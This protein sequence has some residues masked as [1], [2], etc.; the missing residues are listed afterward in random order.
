MWK[1]VGTSLSFSDMSLV[2]TQ[3]SQLPVSIAT[4]D[5]FSSS[6]PQEQAYRETYGEGFPSDIEGSGVRDVVDIPVAHGVS[7]LTAYG[8][9][10][11]KGIIGAKEQGECYC[12]REGK[13]GGGCLDHDYESLD[14]KSSGKRR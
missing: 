6:R 9:A 10:D 1:P 12:G 8:D 3:A 13:E 7:S 4:Y 5:K 2:S 14:C 11:R